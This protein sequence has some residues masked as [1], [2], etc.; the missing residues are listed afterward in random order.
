MLDFEESARDRDQEEDVFEDMVGNHSS[1][2]AKDAMEDI[3][4]ALSKYEEVDTCT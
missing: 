4:V 2:T 1:Y 3:S